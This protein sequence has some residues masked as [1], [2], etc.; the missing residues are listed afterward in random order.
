MKHDYRVWLQPH[1]YPSW[2]CPHKPESLKP[3]P[4]VVHEIYDEPDEEE[5]KLHA[6]LRSYDKSRRKAC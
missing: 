4:S 3:T 6:K 2:I 1:D 5:L